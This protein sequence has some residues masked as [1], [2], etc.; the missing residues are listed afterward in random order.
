MKIYYFHLCDGTDVLLDPEGR[1]LPD[2]NAVIA[3]ALVEARSI[4]GAE[5]LEGS[6]K[7]SQHIDVHDEKGTLVHSLQFEDAVQVTRGE[8]L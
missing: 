2:M 7:M 3:L 8:R 5:A 4:I 6:I 1:W